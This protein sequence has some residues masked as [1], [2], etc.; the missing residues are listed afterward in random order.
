MAGKPP[1]YPTRQPRRCAW[2][3]GWFRSPTPVLPYHK[4]KGAECPGGDK[5]EHSPLSVPDNPDWHEEAAC[6]GDK[7]TVFWVTNDEQSIGK[8]LESCRRCPVLANCFRWAEQDV[9]FS[10]VAGGMVFTPRLRRQLAKED[11]GQALEAQGPD[12]A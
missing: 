11:D 5:R 2:C 8:A 9:A 1:R 3:D 4:A 12:A 6:L 10:G 7:T